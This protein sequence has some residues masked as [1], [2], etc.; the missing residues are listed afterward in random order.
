MK[1]SINLLPKKDTP[2]LDKIVYFALNYLRYIIIITQLVVIGVFF[3]RFQIDQKIIDLKESAEQKK[4]IVQVVLP[5]LTEA[6]NIDKRT[7]EIEKIFKDQNN[8]NKMFQYYISQFP[9][10]INLT[11]L[12]LNAGSVRVMGNAIN[13]KDLQAFYAILKKE[14]HFGIVDLQNIKKTDEGYSFTLLVDK[15]K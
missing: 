4:E 15:Y 10:T 11:N 14:G 9:A 6:G 3:Y 13:P 12:E 7:I 5:L 8:F 2:L 1:Y